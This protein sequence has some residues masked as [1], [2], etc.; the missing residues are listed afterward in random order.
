MGRNILLINW[1]DIQHPEAGG[2]EVHAHEIFSRIA[3]AGHRVTFLT[4]AWPGC[5][6]EA[7]IDGIEVLRRGSNFTFN[8]SVPG[9]VRREL[10]GRGFDILV[11]DVNKI[12]FRSPSFWPGP[13]LI[14]FHHLFG[15]SI[16]RETFFPVASYVWLWEKMIPAFYRGE[17]CQAVSQDTA[18]ELVSLGFERARMKV[19]YNGIESTLYTP[20]KDGDSLPLDGHYCLYMGR[21]KRYKRLD[22]VLEAFARA[23]GEGLES[24][25]RLVFAGAGDDYPRL[26]SRAAALG[27]REAVTFEGRVSLERKLALLRHALAVLN[28]SPKEGWGITNLEASACGAPVIAS[29]SPGLRESVL[30]GESGFLFEPGDVAGFAALICRVAAD[31]GLRERLSRGARE[32]AGRFTWENSA[33]QTIE[34][35]E[36]IIGR[37]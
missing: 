9:I 10:A 11:E 28:P 5:A 6:P 35:I 20:A 16:F 19:V 29:R 1:R 33:A 18:A 15:G 31:S 26:E 7:V 4:C 13:R 3:A 21:I 32:F 30:E 34:H 14:L 24:G 2:A 12:P 8:Y 37:G 23:R 25:L 17:H 27:L 36:Q 22:L